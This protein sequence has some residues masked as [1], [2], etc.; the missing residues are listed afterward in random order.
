MIPALLLAV[1]A[2]VTTPDTLPRVVPLPGVE[3][4]TTR[5]GA[6]A[7]IA[8]TTVTRDELLRDNT[9]LDTP[10]LLAKLPGAY[11]YSDAGNG[12]GYSYLSI[13]GFPQR[14]ISVLVNGVPL[15]DPGS[16]E[17]YWIDH[18]DLLAS[19]REVELQRGVGSALYGAASLGGSVNIETSP[20]T[21]AR[22]ARVAVD[23]GSYDTK[24]LAL[25]MNSGRLD[26]GWNFY[27]RYSRI[28]SQ[29]YREQSWSRLWSYAL[30][31]RHDTGAQSWRANLYGGPEE[32]HLAYIGVTPD[33]LAGQVTGDVGRDRRFNPLTYANE[34]DHFFEPHYELIH[35]WAP[36]AGLALTQTLYE[37]NGKGWYDEQRAAQDLAGYRLQPWT[38]TDTTLFARDYY[39]QDGTGAIAV[40][41][42]NRATVVRA[43]LVRRRTVVNRNYGWVPRLRIDHGR[44]A[45][46]VGGELRAADGRHYGAVIE[47]SGLP[48]GT[49]PDAAYYDVHPRTMNAGVFAREEWRLAPALTT[50]ADLAW[51]HIGY[52]MRGDAFDGVRFDQSYDFVNPRLGVS[53]TARPGLATFASW[54]HGRREPAFSELYNAED[55]GS[56]PLYRVI[57]APNHV[58][59]D[60]L[61][62]PETVDDWELGAS[63]G[64]GA[65][66][67]SINAFHMDFRDELV[68][69]QFIADLG[70]Y[71]FRNAARSAHRGIELAARAAHTVG[72]VRLAVDG[73]ATLSR[74]RLKR[75]REIYGPGIEVSFD[76]NPIA[77]FPDQ[78]VNLG[79]RATWKALTAGADVR[80][81]GRIQL[82]NT[83]L[84][85]ASIAPHTTLDLLAEASA[86]SF[87][88]ADA[89]IGVRVSNV[90]NRRY[91]TGGWMDYDA[92]GSYVPFR[93]PA[94]ER[95]VTVQLR[96]A[97][98]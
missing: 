75:D 8:R 24:R 61:I 42:S 52:H 32:T 98:R 55:F 74:N 85:E 48:P 49:P 83:G 12:I 44:G 76:G 46:T 69:Y 37:F 79:A 57:D 95:T 17:V 20:F 72:P 82:D 16:H 10:M 50:T 88:G 97:Y 23:A 51:R 53:W 19:T 3:V 36:R 92:T 15:N 84:R 40:D 7:P 94:A 62:T 34:R 73:N 47:G 22:E 91:E 28:E 9:G 43:D 29:G 89:R 38:T 96:L 54:S 77:G 71:S 86:P 33:Y 26:G 41:G 60:P 1:A 78:I 90:T 2:T 18:P 70:T 93:I 45:L 6:T 27:G 56:L 68:P 67:A 25:E 14:R 4:S 87:A 30:S 39:A 66:A 80:A 11:A 64:T 63:W 5:P 31:A 35:T 13:R 59:R 21:E 65:V 58:Y 81:A